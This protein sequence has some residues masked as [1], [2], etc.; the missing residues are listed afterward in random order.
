M[1]CLCDKTV[2][3]KIEKVASYLLKPVPS[4]TLIKLFTDL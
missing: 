1:V 4:E 2:V 3:K